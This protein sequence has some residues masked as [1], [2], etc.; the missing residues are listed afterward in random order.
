VGY[1]A[2]TAARVRA[3]LSARSDVVEKRMVG[4]LSFMVEGGMC[5]GVTATGLMV[6]VGTDGLERALAEPHVRPMKI[7]GR[8]LRGFVLVEPEGY[9]TDAALATW[10][11][12]GLDF[13]RTLPGGGR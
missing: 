7:G 1:D 13:V 6:R 5:C 12:R 2:E 4:G 9:R 11:G 8:A 10:V 3:V